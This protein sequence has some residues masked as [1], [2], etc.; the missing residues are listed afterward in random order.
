MKKKRLLWTYL[1]LLCFIIISS[2]I[3]INNS[4]K[5]IYGNQDL[6]FGIMTKI[7]NHLNP[8]LVKEKSIY[9]IRTIT[10]KLNTR[11]S[12]NPIYFPNIKNMDIKTT[13]NQVPVRIYTPSDGN[14]FPL[15]IYSHGGGWVSGDIDEFDNICRKLSKKTKAIVISVNYRLAPEN[16]FPAGLTDVYNV[17]LWVHKNARSIHG[18]SNK[19]CVAGDSAGG[20]LSAAVSQMSRDKNGPSITSTVLIYPSTNIYQL[21]TKSWSN[22]GMDY[23]LTKETFEKFIS[24][25]T[26]NL[27]DRKSKYASPLLAENFEKLPDTL[28]ITAELDPLRAEGEAY[29]NK[30]KDA[31]VNVISTRYKGVTHGFISMDNITGKADEAL[32]QIST[33]LQEQFNKN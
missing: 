1:I 31:G 12:S 15:I 26:P 19:I 30:L 17:L 13:S 20:N 28:I 18:K 33:Y 8:I 4:N 21:N 5:S 16:P 6:F 32:N 3:V 9:E 22:F 23:S 14:N 2:F 11:W 25:Y 24:F 29:G 10:H 27:E 7:G